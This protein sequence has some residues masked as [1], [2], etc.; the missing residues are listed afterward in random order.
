MAYMRGYT[1]HT[2][3]RV[4]LSTDL[5]LIL[6]LGK[7]PPANAF[8]RKED[9]HKEE[10]HFPL[11]IYFCRNCTLV[12]LL[13]AVDAQ[14]LFRD[15]HYLSGASTP[16][17]EHFKEYASSAIRPYIQSKED[18]VIDIGGNDGV[19]LEFVKKFAQVLNVDPADNLRAVSE[20]KGVP[21]YNAFFGSKTVPDLLAAH[22]RPRIVTANNVFAHIDPIRD[23]FAGVASLIGD[24]GVFIFEVHW[25]KHLVEENSFDQI[26]HEHLCF[27][28]LHA[29]KY[30]VEKSGMKI[31]DVEIVS[32][33]GKS[34]R[35][36]ASK[37]RPA[38]TRVDSVLAEEERAGL[39]TEGSYHEFATRVKENKRN[40]VDFIL[41][42]HKEGKRVAGYGAPAKGN[43]L[44]NFYGL[45]PE[46]ISYLTDTTPLKQGLFSPG[47]HIP[48][49]SPDQLRTDPPDYLLLLVWN[50]KDAVLKKEAALRAAGVK[51][52]VTVPRLEV[53]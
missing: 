12:Q 16:L 6:D 18:L 10:L 9:L 32:S 8:L 37:D 2:K 4:C 30:L 11:A 36:F 21:F 44:L 3:C 24:D 26:Y 50:Y 13:D 34:L 33:Q 51:F 47:M 27:Y 42:L 39:T 48:V 23:V 5:V 7:T 28:S 52:I 17:V 19:L 35:V 20:A 15:Y 14:I 49:V 45:G 53:L 29:L 41:N 25:V 46:I 38:S 43:T 31:F 22:G 1:H 40:V